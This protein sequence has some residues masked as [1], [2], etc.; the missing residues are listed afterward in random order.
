MADFWYGSVRMFLAVHATVG[1]LAG[2]SVK[3]PFVAFVLGFVSHFFVD[4]VPHGDLHMYDGYKNGERVKRAILYVAIDGFATVSLI[5]VFFFKQ[6]FFSPLN[7][8]MGI[9][10]GLLPDLLAGLVEI[11]K[12]KS[13]R[14]VSQRLCWF[15]G[16]H[17]K[18]HC[19]LMHR[20]G[21]RDIPFR[22]GLLLQSVVLTM[23]VRMMLRV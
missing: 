17:M 20:F 7:V 12:P 6:D 15:H 23:L 11:F 18:S 16:F 14:W 5:A 22:Y 2:N 19:Y 13:R 4:M 9:I 10:G 3:N 1:A 21:K 8:A